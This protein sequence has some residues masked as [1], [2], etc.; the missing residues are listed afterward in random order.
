M[1]GLNYTVEYNVP[2]IDIPK[3]QYIKMLIFYNNDLKREKLKTN[4][5]IVVGSDTI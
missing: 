5:F 1:R 2:Y 3:P 4:E